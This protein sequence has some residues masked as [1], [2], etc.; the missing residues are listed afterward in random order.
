MGR[1]D[2]GAKPR[3]AFRHG[4]I[5][6]GRR[7]DARF[8]E[9]LREFEGLR[10]I[11]HMDRNNGRLAYFE[12]KTAL[13]QFALEQFRVGPEFPYQFFPFRRIEQRERRLA[14][15]RRGRGVRSR[16]EK[17]PRAEIQ[18]IDQVPRAANVSA[19]RADRFTQR[20]HLDVHAAVALVMVHGPAPA[21]AQHPRSMR[22]V[23]HHDAAIF[24][25]KVA[26]LRQRRDISVH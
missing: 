26:K 10:R 3:L 2:D 16:K 13:L 22:V 9:F 20:T 1:A 7:E 15:R 6:D 11:S 23:H 8:E 18:K 5:T 17:W 19:H 21:A 25:G 14:G 12:L 24:F 4:R